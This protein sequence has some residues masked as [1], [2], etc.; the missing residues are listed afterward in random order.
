MRLYNYCNE[1]E[2][3]NENNDH[4]NKTKTG[5]D[6]NTETDIKNIACLS[7]IISILQ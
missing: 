4:I 3:D 2:N 6:P 7:K 1:N 5:Q